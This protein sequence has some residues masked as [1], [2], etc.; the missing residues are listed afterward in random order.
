VEI[1]NTKDAYSQVNCY[2]GRTVRLND[3]LP[4]LNFTSISNVNYSLTNYLT[5]DQLMTIQRRPLRNSTGMTREENIFF[6]DFDANTTGIIHTMVKR[7]NESEMSFIPCTHKLGWVPST[8]HWE[9]GSKR[10]VFSRR[11]RVIKSADV[12]WVRPS[13]GWLA[14]V[15]PG[16]RSRNATLFNHLSKL[17]PGMIQPAVS[18]S[19]LLTIALSNMSPAFSNGEFA[20]RGSS[21]YNDTLART[22]PLQFPLRYTVSGFGYGPNVTT[23]RISLIILFIYCALTIAHIAWSLGTGVSSSAWDSISEIVALAI[24]S[25]PAHELQNTCAGIRS[26]QVFKK[27]VRVASTDWPSKSNGSMHLELLFPSGEGDHSE[28]IVVN[29]R[30]GAIKEKDKTD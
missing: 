29:E 4:V 27:K 23:V 8:L 13:K 15:N 18:T 10:R 5:T 21:Q 1:R 11:K 26:T 12:L 24:N 3:T 9:E 7:S 6:L 14:R 20:L 30:Y 17:G 22:F 28:S 19:A 2:R 16:L 25:R